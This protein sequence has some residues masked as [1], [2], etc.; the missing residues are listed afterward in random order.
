VPQENVPVTIAG[1]GVT[2]AQVTSAD[3]CAFFA[4]EPVGAYTVTL[5]KPGY[6]SDQLASMPSQSATVGAGS[7]VSLQFQYDN[8]AIMN[9]TLTGGAGG[10]VPAN[11]PVTLANTHLLPGGTKVFA[12]TGSS[13][14]LLGLFPYVD[15]Y[16]S[17]A[18]SCL[19]ADPEG[20]NAV[21]A[22]IYPGASRPAATAVT[23]GGTSSATVPLHTVIVHTQT[24][25]GAP[26]VGST[27]TARNATDTGC[28]SVVIYTLGVTDAAGN[29]TAALP[30]GTWSFGVTSGTGTLVPQLLSPLN[31][32][33]PTVTIQW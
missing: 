24:T 6:V 23:P 25:V 8:A 3:G 28:P 19:A 14:V 13:R 18:G 15:G 20:V 9:L 21:G 12:G 32:T 31:G 4:F 2:D 11:I 22:A 10:T 16:E 7:I 5:N 1:P 27:V 17:F 29:F 26:R 30:Y 33:T